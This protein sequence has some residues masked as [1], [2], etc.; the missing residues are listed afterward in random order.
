MKRD[1]LLDVRSPAYEASDDDDE[2]P[3]DSLGGIMVPSVSPG[4]PFA[5]WNEAL[6]LQMGGD[7]QAQILPSPANL[8]AAAGDF[9]PLEGDV[10]EFGLSDPFFTQLH[11]AFFGI[12]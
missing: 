2:K 10:Q 9:R 11:E 7:A 1:R 12:S 6:A 4:D 5:A 3:V 8:T